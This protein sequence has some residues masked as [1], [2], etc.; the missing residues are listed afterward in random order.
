MPA[1]TVPAKIATEPT[2]YLS[3]YGKDGTFQGAAYVA[4]NGIDMKRKTVYGLKLTDSE[5][6]GMYGCLQAA[7]TL[8]KDR[9]LSE[10]SLLVDFVADI[11]NA[12]AIPHVISDR[13]D[14]IIRKTCDVPAAV[15]AYKLEDLAHAYA[16]IRADQEATF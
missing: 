3:H 11:H 14:T 15:N 9:D 4:A 13:I 8:A 5:Y 12:H 10:V 6:I 1:I 2:H 16:E 7:K